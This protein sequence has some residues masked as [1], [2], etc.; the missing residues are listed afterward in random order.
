M[1]RLGQQLLPPVRLHL[2]AIKAQ[3]AAQLLLVP[4]L[5]LDLQIMYC[6]L[7]TGLLVK[8]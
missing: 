8:R 1:E 5:W 3:Q 2:L 4:R 7:L 6:R